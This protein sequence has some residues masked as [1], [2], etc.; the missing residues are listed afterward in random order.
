VASRGKSVRFELEPNETVN[1]DA[2]A[3]QHNLRTYDPA[4]DQENARRR[5]AL[6]LLIL[7]SV[8]VIALLGGTFADWISVD[9]SGELAQAILSPVVVL[10]GTAL[11]FYFG[12]QSNSG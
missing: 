9:E 10:T 2:L 11:G 3:D 4:K 1:L 12:G 6:G 5:L 7:L 8:V